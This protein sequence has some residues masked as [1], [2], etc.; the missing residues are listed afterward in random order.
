MKMPKLPEIRG[1]LLLLFSISGF[2]LVIVSSFGNQIEW[3]PP[4]VLFGLFGLIPITYWLGIGVM[5]LSL[6]L[7]L[8][9]KNIEIFA[10]QFLLIYISL[11]STPA[12]F[13]MYPS[14]WDSYMH[15][16]SSM[17]IV[18]TGSSLNEGMFSYSANYP[19]FFVLTAVY[20][21][22][23]NPP[24]LEMLRF[25]P[26]VASLFTLVALYLVVRTYVP[27]LGLRTAL[28]LSALGNVWVQYS[29]SPQ[30]LGLA[31]A[32]LVFVFLEKG[33]AKWILM[34]LAAFTY[35]AIS[36]PTSMFFV[37]GAL[38]LREVIVR[39]RAFRAKESLGER[40]WPI[41]VFIIVWVLWLI[42]GARM[43]SLFLS[44]LMY[45]KLLLPSRCGAAYRHHAYRWQHLSGESP[46]A[47]GAPWGVLPPVRPGGGA[48]P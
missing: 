26:F 46:A 5:A 35:L 39:F 22:L 11:W 37:V 40:S 20:S 6:L 44:S 48:A 15:Y 25:Y 31:A 13:E 19:G 30:S 28:V 7:G 4:N 12:L 33:G 1:S 10:V 18:D 27:T 42:T 29:F 32:L 45:Q 23:G 3:L 34:A 16:F 9:N 41:S 14:A 17:T 38:V 8:G 21:L 24:I 43:Y 2:T 36:H 47:D